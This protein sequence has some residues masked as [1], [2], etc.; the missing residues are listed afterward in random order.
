MVDTID[1]RWELADVAHVTRHGVSRTQIDDMIDLGFWITTANP[2]GDRN[3][4]LVIGP[5]G[6][7]RILTLVAQALDTP[8]E[9][10]PVAC[11]P[12]TE[13][14]EAVYWRRVR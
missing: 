6:L 9:Y 10:V 3:R 2:T 1:L 13:K 7:G 5:T 8:G 14:E 4:P 12:S 11:W